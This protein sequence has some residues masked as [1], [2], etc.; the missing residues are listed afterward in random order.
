MI[1][2]N[3]NIKKLS[4]LRVFMASPFD[5]EKIPIIERTKNET[6]TVAYTNVGNGKYE[7]TNCKF[8]TRETT[9]LTSN[10]PL[11]ISFEDKNRIHGVTAPK[12]EA[13]KVRSE[14]L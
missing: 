5:N 8:G 1:E 2:I 10:V 13:R 14:K 7:M 12:M 9:C 3:S 11:K 4:L 6:K